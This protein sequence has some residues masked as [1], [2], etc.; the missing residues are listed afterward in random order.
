MDGS[1]SCWVYVRSEPGLWT[2]G[3][4]DPAGHWQPDDDF[5]SR[6]DAAARVSYLNGGA[7]ARR[8]EAIEDTLDRA[9]LA[10]IRGITP[11]GL[12]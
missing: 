3:F 6:E 1:G 10:A 2:T 11:R 5:A 8:V 9:E 7:L 12:D 4:Y